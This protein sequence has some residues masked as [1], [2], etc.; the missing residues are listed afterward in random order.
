[1]V[2]QIGLLWL[3]RSPLVWPGKAC[4]DKGKV[5]GLFFFFFFILFTETMQVFGDNLRWGRGKMW[6]FVIKRAAGGNL[7]CGAGFKSEPQL[8]SQ[9]AQTSGVHFRPRPQASVGMTVTAVT[10]AT[11]GWPSFTGLASLPVLPPRTGRVEPQLAVGLQKG[12]KT[13][14]PFDSTESYYA[15]KP[16]NATELN[17]K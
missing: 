12:S 11:T 3:G 10:S 17:K 7:D 8:T 2:I 15:C 6:G 9:P 16:C 5:N 13:N 14:Q 4:S 1:M